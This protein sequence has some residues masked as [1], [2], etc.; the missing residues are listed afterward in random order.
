MPRVQIIENMQPIAQGKVTELS[1]ILKEEPSEDN[2]VF[3]AILYPNRSL[4]D[5]GFLVVMSVFIL[6]NLLLGTLFYAIGAWPVLGFCGLYIVLVWFAFKASYRHGRMHERFLM[7]E[8]EIWVSR[9]L[10]SGHETHWR[11]ESFW[12]RVFIDD[13]VCHESQIQLTSKGRTLV[14]GSFLSPPERAEFANALKRA[15][16]KIRG[17]V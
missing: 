2:P 15:L 14:V 5:K 8:G 9:V 1:A 7:T 17:G 16:E 3:E 12:T 11:L 4:P 10:P 6:A 13:P